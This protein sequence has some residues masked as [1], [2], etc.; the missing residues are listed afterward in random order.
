ME[1]AYLGKATERLFLPLLQLVLPE[2]VDMDLPIEG[3]FHNC[4]IVSSTR[5]TRAT[6]AR[7]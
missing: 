7:S 2:V 4:V 6:P 1:D 5:G 3:V